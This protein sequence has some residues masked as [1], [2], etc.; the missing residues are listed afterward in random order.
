M[1]AERKK[2]LFQ[3]PPVHVQAH[4]LGQITL[5]DRGDRASHFRRRPKQILHQRIHRNFHFAPG[6]SR[7]AEPRALG[8]STLFSDSLPH[9]LE[10]SR[11][12]LIGSDNFVK[13]IGNFSVQAGPVT[14]KTDREISVSHRLEA[15]QNHAEVCG[16]V[17]ISTVVSVRPRDGS[18]SSF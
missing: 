16:D 2:S 18:C 9:A 5:R 17:S 6:A 7:L 11:H 14:R 13:R 4:R 15:P 10:F 8:R 12:L 1:F 3:R